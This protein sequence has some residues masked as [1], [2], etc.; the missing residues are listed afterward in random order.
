M[1]DEQMWR[2][3]AAAALAPLIPLAISWGDKVLQ[4]WRERRAA[5]KA[6]T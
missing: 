2:I 1:T 5:K 3:A 6:R 4:R